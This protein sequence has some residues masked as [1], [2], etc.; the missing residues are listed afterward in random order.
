MNIASEAV[1]E[2]LLS[3]LPQFNPPPF[4]CFSHLHKQPTQSA[5][6]KPRMWR[7]E[8]LGKNKPLP[9]QLLR[10]LNILIA[11]L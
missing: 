9:V 10:Y 11:A 2:L 5:F 1:L 4:L 8:S 7:V 6:E 3:I